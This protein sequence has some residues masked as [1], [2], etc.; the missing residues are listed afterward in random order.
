VDA[1]PLASANADWASDGP[2][3][4][5]DAMVAAR[6]LGTPRKAAHAAPAAVS[7]EPGDRWRL[8]VGP[9]RVDR[10]PQG[11]REALASAHGARSAPLDL[12]Y[13]LIR[14]LA[15]RDSTDAWLGVASDA[16]GRADAWRLPWLR[17]L[18]AR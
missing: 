3:G 1:E 12:D 18:S 13:E 10:G 16:A 4:C 15:G 14:R 5:P 6:T 11:Q 9:T 7:G 2:Q 17:M 8:S